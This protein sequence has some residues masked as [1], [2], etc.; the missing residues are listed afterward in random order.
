MNH[1]KELWE[2][3]RL[4]QKTY[5]IERFHNVASHA[6]IDDCILTLH[7]HEHMEFIRME[8]G[9]AIFYIDSKP[10][11][12]QPGEV[13]LLPGGSLHVGYAQSEGI[14]IYDSLVFNSSLFGDWLHDPI[15][16]QMLAPFIEG[17]LHFPVAVS[18]DTIWDHQFHEALLHILNELTEVKEGYQLIVKT[19]LY[20]L[21]VQLARNYRT[22]NHHQQTHLSSYYFANRERFKQL[23]HYVEQHYHHKLTVN[24]A[25]TIV[26]LD[27]FHFCKQFK[28]LTGRTFIEYVNMCRVNEAER[29]LLDSEYAIYEIASLVGCDNAN[30]F[31]K[32]YKQYKGVTPSQVRKAIV[33]TYP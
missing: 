6:R 28:K 14:I 1:P 5:P 23:L 27:P 31:S 9:T 10:Y 8:T 19:T 7:W 25:A 32:L 13:L 20:G 2:N 26:N 4:L 22:S 24:Y 12:L 30:Y 11:P 3:T 16:A 33:T 21:L 29:L 18:L 15:H 17:I